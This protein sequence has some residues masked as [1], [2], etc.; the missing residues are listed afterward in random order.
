ME[1]VITHFSQYIALSE[2][3]KGEIV[4]RIQLKSFKKGELVHHA[5]KICTHSYFIQKGILRTYFYK[6]G[7]EISEYFCRSC[8]IDWELL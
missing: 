5:E 8:A 6:D 3:L 1:Q 2:E 7:K 4:N